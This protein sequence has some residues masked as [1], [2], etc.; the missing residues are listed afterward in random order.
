MLKSFALSS[1]RRDSFALELVS[2]KGLSW[3]VLYLHLIFVACLDLPLQF[4]MLAAF[5]SVRNIS[6][7]WAH[8]GT[9]AQAQFQALYFPF[10]LFTL[11]Y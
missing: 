9:H 3:N 4:L 2:L 10:R 1:T 11:S 5:K 6:G 7:E 8:P